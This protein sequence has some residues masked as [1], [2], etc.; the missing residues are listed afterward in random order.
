MLSL[1]HT[2]KKRSSLGATVCV[3]L[4]AV[5]GPALASQLVIKSGCNFVVDVPGIIGATHLKY[6]VLKG[7]VYKQDSDGKYCG[8]A[9]METPFGPSADNSC[10]VVASGQLVSGDWGNKVLSSTCLLTEATITAAIDSNQSAPF[11]ASGP[12]NF[13]GQ[14]FLKTVGGEIKTCAGEDVVLIPK[15]S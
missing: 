12:A 8:T 2:F 13:H 15:I 5:S 4:L 6:N 10:F 11:T 7:S 9:T 14:A 3:C 1:L